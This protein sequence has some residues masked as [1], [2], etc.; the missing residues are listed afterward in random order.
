MGPPETRVNPDLTRDARSAQSAALFE[1]ARPFA[2][3]E[4]FPEF[5][6]GKTV[7]KTDGVVTTASPDFI[8]PTASPK[9]PPRNEAAPT[10]TSAGEILQVHP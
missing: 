1:D 6:P 3:I 2:I 4:G 8:C 7:G 5:Q 9:R 10:A